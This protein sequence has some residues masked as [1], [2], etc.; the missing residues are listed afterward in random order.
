MKLTTSEDNWKKADSFGRNWILPKIGKRKIS[1]LTEQSLQDIIDKAYAAGLAKK[2][3][4]NLRATLMAFLK[5]CRKCKVTALSPEELVI[6][7]GAAVGQKQILQPEHFIK[8]FTCDTTVERKKRVFDEFIYAY[9]FQVMTGLR[10]GE[11]LGLKWSDIKGRT[12]Y[13]Q[14]SRN[15]HNTITTGKNGNAIRHFAI[16]DLAAGIL[17]ERG[18][19][20]CDCE[21]V[22]G[23]VCQSTFSKRWSRYCSSNG[24]PH[25]APYEMRHTFVSLAKNLPEGSVKALVGHSKN[26][27]TFGTY[28]HEVNGE[29]EKTAQ[30]L[31]G[32]FSE[33]LKS[34]L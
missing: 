12:V 11:L 14:R 13:V 34:V 16:S 21:Y 5:Y 15:I 10:P 25:I 32:I 3:L 8:L 19:L 7:R 27:D 1:A 6:P 30:R 23:G 20:T 33:I 28:G 2:T 17:E 22:F 26:M 9:R 4:E 18:K 31:D 24:I 29:L